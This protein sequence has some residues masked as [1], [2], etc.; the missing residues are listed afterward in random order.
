[1][2]RCANA[3]GKDRIAGGRAWLALAL[4]LVS[5]LVGCGGDDAPTNVTVTAETTTTPSGPAPTQPPA[6][7]E[8]GAVVWTTEVDPQ[9]K[10][11]T[12]AVDAFPD[13]APTI[14]AALPVRDLPPGTMLTAD[15]TYN[16][17]SLDG[18][19]TT[20]VAPSGA[21]SGWVEFHL[22]RSAEPWPDGTYAIS[23]SAG[24]EVVQTAEVAIEHG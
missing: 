8:I 1:M 2:D 14:F 4:G 13:D 5:V 11:P 24:G 21:A 15:W 17:T 12:Q 10:A 19:T 6:S 9:T 16:S 20:A 18:L 23:V 3:C 22:T 7:L